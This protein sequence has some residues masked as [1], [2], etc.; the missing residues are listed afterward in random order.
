MKDFARRTALASSAAAMM[1]GFARSA[2]AQANP[3]A[4]LYKAAQQE[5]SVTW[6]SVPMPTSTAERVGK[7]FTKLY[8]GRRC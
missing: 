4:D 6:Y 2:S 1:L 5:G 3:L 8:P 7:A